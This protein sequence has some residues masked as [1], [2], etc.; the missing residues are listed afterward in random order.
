MFYMSF[1]VLYRCL[2]VLYMFLYVLYM[3]LCFVCCVLCVV[4]V[5]IDE[6]V[7][8]IYIVAFYIGCYKFYVFI[9]FI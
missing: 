8:S 1:Y 3:F 9:R 5:H 4:C 7:L 6:Q 2:Y